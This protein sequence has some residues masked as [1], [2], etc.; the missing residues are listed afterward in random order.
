MCVKERIT[1]Q[2]KTK[3]ECC[4]SLDK[5]RVGGIYL[6]ELGLWESACMYWIGWLQP[7]VDRG[8]ILDVCSDLFVRCGCFV[9]AT[10][11]RSA[12][13]R[14]GALFLEVACLDLR[15]FSVGL[16][17]GQLALFERCCRRYVAARVGHEALR[18]FER[19]VAVSGRVRTTWVFAHC[20]ATY[21]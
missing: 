13:E 14:Q 16:L 15:Q 10:K 2:N 5:L 20:F 18:G 21:N 6:V 4:F 1:K 11:S 3:K 19:T 17:G 9:T 7:R 12:F 8:T